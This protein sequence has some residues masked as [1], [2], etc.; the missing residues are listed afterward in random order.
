ME[1]T[2]TTEAGVADAGASERKVH[3]SVHQLCW[4]NA[5]RDIEGR[6]ADQ[7]LPNRRYEKRHGM[8]MDY[9]RK[10]GRRAIMSLKE[11]RLTPDINGIMRHPLHFVADYFI[12]PLRDEEC[13]IS[14]HHMALAGF[15][16]MKQHPTDGFT[17]S[18]PFYLA[19]I[20]DD[21]AFVVVDQ[22]LFDFHEEV[23]GSKTAQPHWGCAALACLY[24]L[25]ERPGYRFIVESF[26]L[27]V[28]EQHKDLCTRWIR[29]VL[30]ERRAARFG[31]ANVQRVIRTGDFNLFPDKPSSVEQ[32]AALEAEF[33]DVS[34]ELGDVNTGKRV[35]STF[36]PAPQDPFYPKGLDPFVEHELSARL[37]CILCNDG[38]AGARCDAWVLATPREKL[39]IMS[40]LP[41]SD[42]FPVFV[43]FLV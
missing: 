4:Q 20:Y 8:F 6:G 12:M 19:Q 13:A 9:V 23:M 16:C 29:D 37:D 32:A 1:V 11:L 43:E 34:R 36:F 38:F 39:W 10:F 24:E 40:H 21:G 42:H 26:H 2:E 7:G 5:R 22:H 33:V 18:L 30:P 14:Q 27:P 31:A 17:E 35:F 28:E 3:F 15:G 41:I 25:R